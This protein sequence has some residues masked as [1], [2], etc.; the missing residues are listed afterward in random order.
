MKDKLGRQ[1]REMWKDLVNS[2]GEIEAL[3]KTGR[4]DG[5]IVDN[6]SLRGGIAFTTGNIVET[7]VDHW[8]LNYKWIL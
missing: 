3:V 7:K 1:F 2:P 5:K 6:G 4:N 8:G